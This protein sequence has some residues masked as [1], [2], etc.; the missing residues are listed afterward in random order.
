VL[1]KALHETLGQPADVMLMNARWPDGAGLARDARA[2]AEMGVIQDLVRAVRQVRN[3]TMIGERKLLVAAIAAR[4]PE[5][6]AVLSQHRETVRALAFLEAYEVGETAVRAK[7]SATAVAGGIEIF[8]SLPGEVDTAKLKEVLRLR[9]D[10]V[11]AGIGQVKAKLANEGFLAKADP[12]VV[13]EERARLRE[14]ELELELLERN[15]AGL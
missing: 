12:E 10:K 7:N 14:L 6:R 13:E 11:R 2:E 15:L 4:R 1:W 9:V 3:L 5:D 8:V